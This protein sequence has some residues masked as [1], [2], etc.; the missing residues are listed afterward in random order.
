MKRKIKV[1]DINYTDKIKR[2]PYK[3]KKNS[4]IQD[5]KERDYFEKHNCPNCGSGQIYYRF[6]TKDYK[7]KLCKLIFY[8]D[9]NIYMEVKNLN[10]KDLHKIYMVLNC[11]TNKKDD[12]LK[13]HTKLAK[14]LLAG[15]GNIQW[16][17]K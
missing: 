6:N 2:D 11:L 5:E 12:I 4:M 15:R 8:F 16:E 14:M 1:T 9:R 3:R 13:I 7:C 17:K 10:Q